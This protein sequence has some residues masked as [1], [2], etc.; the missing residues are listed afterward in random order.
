M[1]HHNQY[2]SFLG[3]KM[4][5]RD[6]SRPSE[7]VA[8]AAANARRNGIPDQTV[9]VNTLRDLIS[10][11]E[12]LGKDA[13][14]GDKKLILDSLHYYK[15]QFSNTL[16]RVDPNQHD[17]EGLEQEFEAACR[18]VA[19]AV[20]PGQIVHD[21]DWAEPD[22][23]DEEEVPVAESF[24]SNEAQINHG[25]PHVAESPNH[26]ENQRIL[27]RIEDRVRILENIDDDD[28]IR[29]FVHDDNS[30]KWYHSIVNGN[31]EDGRKLRSRPAPLLGLIER[32]NAAC[33]RIDQR[34][35]E[36]RNAMSPARSTEASGTDVSAA[37]SSRHDNF[38]GEELDLSIPV[39]VYN[40]L[41][42][43]EVGDV[44]LPTPST[45]KAS[46]DALNTMRE[47][48]KQAKL[49]AQ[50]LE[51]DNDLP[52][53]RK[54]IK[55]GHRINYSQMANNSQTF[56]L[57]GRDD[58][59]KVREHNRIM[60]EY[61]RVLEAIERK[62]IDL[63]TLNAS[64]VTN[65]RLSST[66]R[67][68]H[69]GPAPRTIPLD[70][71]SSE[72]NEDMLD[73]NSTGEGTRDSKKVDPRYRTRRRVSDLESDDEGPHT[74]PS[75][76]RAGLPVST[77]TPST[78]QS[79]HRQDFPD[80][81]VI[82]V[83]PD[84][85]A[86]LEISTEHLNKLNRSSRAN[87]ERAGTLGH[88][89]YSFH[90]VRRRNA[91]KVIPMIFSKCVFT[92]EYL[93]RH[94]KRSLWNMC[95]NLCKGLG[96]KRRENNYEISELYREILGDGLN[97]MEM[98][99]YLAKFRELHSRLVN[100]GLI[101]NNAKDSVELFRPGHD[102]NERR[103]FID[104]LYGSLYGCGIYRA[105]SRVLLRKHLFR[106]GKDGVTADEEDN[107]LVNFVNTVIAEWRALSMNHS[108]EP[109]QLSELEASWAGV[110]SEM[111]TDSLVI[112]SMDPESIFSRWEASFNTII[113][114]VSL[115][116]F[117]HTIVRILPQVFSARHT[118]SD[119]V[120]IEAFTKWCVESNW[121]D[122]AKASAFIENLVKFVR[123]DDLPNTALKISV[124]ELII[125]VLDNRNGQT[126]KDAYIYFLYSMFST[127]YGCALERHFEVR[128]DSKVSIVRDCI[129]KLGRNFMHLGDISLT[130][131]QAVRYFP[132]I[133]SAMYHR[134]E[135]MHQFEFMDS[136]DES[137]RKRFVDESRDIWMNDRSV[138]D[139]YLQKGVEAVAGK[140]GNSKY[141]K[142]LL[143]LPN[144]GYMYQEIENLLQILSQ[145]QVSLKEETELGARFTLARLCLQKTAPKVST[146]L[147]NP[148]TRHSMN[149]FPAMTDVPVITRYNGGYPAMED[150]IDEIMK[151]AY[152][153]EEI[154]IGM[155]LSAMLESFCLSGR[156]LEDFNPM[157]WE[158]TSLST[159]AVIAVVANPQIND[160]L[161]SRICQMITNG[162]DYV[163]S[164][165]LFRDSSF[166]SD[167]AVNEVLLDWVARIIIDVQNSAL[168]MRFDLA[169]KWFYSVMIGKHF[170][171]REDNNV[172]VSDLM[173][174]KNS[175][176]S[177]SYIESWKNSMLVRAYVRAH[178]AYVGHVDT[179]KDTVTNTYES[180]K[181]IADECLSESTTEEIKKDIKGHLKNVDGLSGDT[182]I[183][184][185][186]AIVHV[187][188][189]FGKMNSS[190]E[191]DPRFSML[192]IAGCLLS[193]AIL[194]QKAANARV[195][196]RKMDRQNRKHPTKGQSEKL[197]TNDSKDLKELIEI[198]ESAIGH[199]FEN[200]F[201]KGLGE[202]ALVLER[203]IKDTC[204][205]RYRNSVDII[206][207]ETLH[208]PVPVPKPTPAPKPA[209][210]PR[211]RPPLVT[212]TVTEI[213][214]KPFK[215]HTT[216]SIIN[217]LL[218]TLV[219][220]CS[221][222]R[223]FKRHFDEELSVYRKITSSSGTTLKMFLD[224]C[225]DTKEEERML[226]DN[227]LVDYYSSRL[228]RR[229]Q[230]YCNTGMNMVM[231]IHLTLTSAIRGDSSKGD[232]LVVEILKRVL[233]KYPEL[234]L[235]LFYATAGNINEYERCSEFIHT[236]SM[237]HDEIRSIVINN[238]SL[239]ENA[240]STFYVPGRIGEPVD[241]GKIYKIINL[242]HL[243]EV[244][245][246]EYMQKVF[247]KYM[248]ERLSLKMATG[249]TR[250][251]HRS[252]STPTS[253]TTA[254]GSTP[255]VAHTPMSSSHGAGHS[256][257]HGPKARHAGKETDGRFS[258]GKSVPRFG[259]G[260]DREAINLAENEFQGIFNHINGNGYLDRLI[261]KAST[262]TVDESIEENL[263]SI[264]TQA[265]EAATGSGMMDDPTSSLFKM[266]F[267]RKVYSK[268]LVDGTA[269]EA[270]SRAATELGGRVM[271]LITNEENAFSALQ[272][273]QKETETQGAT[274]TRGEEY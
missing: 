34:I 163:A 174:I 157:N 74:I 33:A 249:K 138:N 101:S 237:T 199:E 61:R 193:L 60:S 185:C 31:V 118:F 204:T 173:E 195:V 227:K 216:Q 259:S 268:I 270:N 272:R 1:H 183:S 197:D 162:M 133:C 251:V 90:G 165:G 196:A 181:A 112:V 191:V 234:L 176:F 156:R 140:F 201:F 99:E 257:A 206:M 59:D 166:L 266:V 45:R 40:R 70:D 80:V 200:E 23:D 54:N 44:T 64:R 58:P 161:I 14:S 211:T 39:E 178:E 134:G 6:D 55:G 29:L 88:G 241:T 225:P 25:I 179:T 41:Q 2:K 149:E 62:G 256:M 274:E 158:K 244:L 125:G 269:N 143:I 159:E 117:R 92:R 7:R 20:R 263:K 115:F 136:V 229:C 43:I 255:A 155:F 205:R 10:A 226:L 131:D 261:A 132:G 116:M 164:E 81:S 50:S 127:F 107:G 188:S 177:K 66:A 9:N 151:I 262:Y 87:M 37:R 36:L 221:D 203:S 47:L 108:D 238:R 68:S 84:M 56:R 57:Y 213:E 111:S 109:D 51:E 17:T 83:D 19:S 82:H 217:G 220:M 30:L 3:P 75:V 190:G 18:T 253:S 135:L 77:S 246:A 198:F 48:L 210:A 153:E 230:K 130:E 42:P 214:D 224:D 110:L 28:E 71:D 202:S 4:A 89:N 141:P 154:E 96:Y 79:D 94:P 273:F 78:E 252:D 182:V 146:K 258:R 194:N 32:H 13:K 97:S 239:V 240:I 186:T 114:P 160:G 152:I 236:S 119:I 207:S 223:Y 192:R 222:E 129:E 215:R 235:F 11:V 103:P 69:A 49:R 98:V 65:S 15:S 27:D 248:P 265:V 72:D 67:P 124:Q 5:E 212:F 85:S 208:V 247:Q 218:Q 209:P 219:V 180:F 142:D 102:T 38:S 93:K 35:E 52:L 139:L 73:V 137:L 95:Q 91:K 126:R 120:I 172:P 254:H 76:R 175:M 144:F 12:R 171:T 245:D 53:V 46:D 187:L 26:K 150:L 122:P 22:I 128:E 86:S 168:A 169:M 63:S 167:D 106:I 104:S 100:S 271:D 243:F 21:D 145:D 170:T 260:V 250:S 231:M 228:E 184:Q 121:M 267:W 123:D 242:A 147:R 189:K 105:S 232:E 233:P 113:E 16:R 8:A 264:E 148:F 24:R